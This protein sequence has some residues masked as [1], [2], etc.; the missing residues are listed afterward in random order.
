MQI[1]LLNLTQS[2]HF[3]TTSFPKHFFS[4]QS[5]VFQNL[6][7]NNLRH[8]AFGNFLNVSRNIISKPVGSTVCS[9]FLW[10]TLQFL[11]SAGLKEL[12]R[13][14]EE[15]TAK[16]KRLVEQKVRNF[17]SWIRM[18]LFAILHFYKPSPCFAT[19]TCFINMLFKNAVA[20][21]ENL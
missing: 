13:E 14:M 20:L 8:S 12:Q 18:F 6:D 5:I 4:L 11:Y 17:I 16:R 21:I 9:F 2:K 10:Q 7:P 1:G 19:F 15:Q 3:P